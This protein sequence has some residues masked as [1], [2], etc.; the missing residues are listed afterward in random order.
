MAMTDQR[1]ALVADDRASVR[2]AA[3]AGGGEQIVNGTT[4]IDPATDVDG[5]IWL[6]DRPGAKTR[7]RVVGSKAS[8]L[9]AQPLAGLDVRSLD[10]SPEAARYVITVDTGD[11]ASVR[12]GRIL[13]DAKGVPTGLSTPRRVGSGGAG[14]S[15]AVWVDDVRVSYLAETET[16]IQMQTAL[17]DGST[18]STTSGALLP[19]ADISRLV[20]GSGPGALTY[21]TDPRGR[22]WYLRPSGNWQLVDVDPVRSLGNSR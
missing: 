5:K 13:R 10:I 7:V 14:A 19:A 12:V 9:D 21:A 8:T 18:G 6:V 2:I 11:A 15:S 4:F 22:L 16:G 1:I 3:L 17:I 20:V